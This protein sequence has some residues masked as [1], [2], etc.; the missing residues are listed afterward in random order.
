MLESHVEAHLEDTVASSYIDWLNIT[1]CW[2]SKTCTKRAQRISRISST[3]DFRHFRHFQQFYDF[4]HFYDFQDN[5]DFQDLRLFY[6]VL[7]L[8]YRRDFKKNRRSRVRLR[9]GAKDLRAGR[10]V[11]LPAM[12]GRITLW[13]GSHRVGSVKF[14]DTY[15]YVRYAPPVLADEGVKQRTNI[16]SS[17]AMYKEI[18]K[19]FGISQ[20][21]SMS[22]DF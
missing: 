1:P 7:W 10:A 3:N 22:H 17:T 15:P 4:Q 14:I 12:A 16:A 19:I 5:K 21:I 20:Q 2:D 13:S 18:W 11:H 9:R 6:L 8:F